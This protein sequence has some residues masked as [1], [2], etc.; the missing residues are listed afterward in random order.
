MHA[1]VMRAT[2]AAAYG[3]LRWPHTTP[4]ET[5]LQVW[6][7]TY[8]VCLTVWKKRG[9]G[10]CA[11]QMSVIFPTFAVLLFGAVMWSADRQRS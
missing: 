4:F 6:Y 2:S 7:T 10:A 9:N 1:I 11:I 5:A 8:T 3:F